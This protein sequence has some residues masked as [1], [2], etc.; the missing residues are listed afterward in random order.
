MKQKLLNKLWLRVGMIVAIMTTALSG[1]AWA[2][3]ETI[4]FPTSSA[5]VDMSS[6]GVSV[7][8]THV[9]V[10]IS[11]GTGSNLATNT[12]GTRIY[13]G[14]SMVFTS[15]DKKISKIDFTYK[16][17]KKQTNGVSADNG[18]FTTAFTVGNSQ[19]SNL[20]AT[21]EASNETTTTVTFT[22]GS[23]SGNYALQSAEVTFVETGGSSLTPSDLAITG[24]PVALNFDLYPSAT[25]QTVSYTTSSTGA[26]TVSGGTGYVTT[27]VS[28]NTIT[29]TPTAV[30]PSAQTITVSQEADATYAAGSKT[31]TVSVADSSPLANIAALTAK[32]TAANY[33]VAL[34]NAVVTYVNGNYAYIQDASGAVAMYKSGHGLTAGDVLNGTATVAYQL[35]NN[36]PQITSLSGVTPE[37]GDAPSPTTIAQSAWSYTF[38]NVLSQYFQITGA[39]ITTNN[40]KYY[41]SLNNEDVQLYKASGSIS[42]LDLSKTYTITGFPTLYNST[43]E[44]QIYED[45]VAPKTDPTISFNDGSVRVGATLDLSTLFT[46]NSTGAVTYSITAGGS[47]ATIDGSTLTGTAEGSVTVKAA[48]A[49]SS[50]YNAGEATATITVNPALVLS[51]IA[52]TTAPTKTTYNE[53]ESFDPTGMVVTATYTDNSTE[54]ITGYTCSPDGALTTSDTEI[55]IS[56]TE[57]GVTKTTTQAITVNEVVDYA[58]LPFEWNDTSTP[59]GITNSGV[60]TYNSSPYQKFDTQGDYLVLKINERPGKLTFDIKNNSFSGGTFKVQTSVDGDTYTDLKVYSTITGTQNEEFT[61]LDANVR[62]IKWVYTNKSSGNVALGNIAL[63]AY[64]APGNSAPVWSELPTPTIAVNEEY[65]LNLSTYV[66]G[67]PTPTISLSTSISSSLYEFEDGLLVFQ[68]TAAGTYEFT[69]TATNSEGSANATLTVTAT[70]PTPSTGGKW[71]QTELANLTENNIFV[72]VGNNGSTYAMTNDNGASS[73]PSTAAVTIENSS[74]SGAIADNIKWNLGIDSEGYIFYPNGDTENWLYCTNTNNGVRVGTNTNNVFT[75]NGDYLYNIATS[76]YVGIYNSQDWRCYTSINSNI[77][78]QTFSFYKQVESVKLNDSYGYATYASTSPLDFTDYETAGYSA[79]AVESISGTTITFTQIT[80]VVPAGTGMLLMGTAGAT[81]NLNV[82]NTAGS[83]IT[84]KL[85]GITSATDVTAGQ[86]YG[87][88]G[89]EFV[90]VNAGTIP[91]GKALLPASEVSAG[92]KAFTFVFEDDATGIEETL[93]NSP[94]KGENIYNLAGQMVNGKSVNGKLPKGIYIVNGKKVMK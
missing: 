17:N 10:T 63:A 12:D 35:H 41:V 5:N 33:T 75:L 47:Y 50:S 4:T 64:V 92:V 76:R 86:Y 60:G 22:V 68:P 6:S 57:S 51:S 39:T 14:N 45:P 91:A 9:S 67:T 48:Q 20:S 34:N 18:S 90:P 49:E 38:S 62:Y 87:L 58:T 21:W 26:V 59:T 88:K 83:A 30:T 28:G 74:L 37:S 32:T 84:N 93:S 16:R 46:S 81:I 23:G 40:N 7:T 1:T 8:G 52:V 66:T 69:F 15:T 25:A 65:E 85:V 79:W 27:S 70:A 2:E 19:A 73:A 77:Q 94:L 43:K 24:A 29:V 44:L 72:I 31:F 36:N 61:N 11:K 42:S 56:Y 53:G 71:I 82:S 89:N 54:A 80:G 3:T 13:N 55:T 78:N